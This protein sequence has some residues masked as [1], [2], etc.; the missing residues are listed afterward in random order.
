MTDLASSQGS[1]H[2]TGPTTLHRHRLV[3]P[4]ERCAKLQRMIAFCEQR[5]ANGCTIYA[6]MAA[7]MRTEL[8]TLQ[9]HDQAAQVM[10]G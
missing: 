7:I 1:A 6:G 10:V 9:V 2:Y 8:S 4:A 3:S 5:A